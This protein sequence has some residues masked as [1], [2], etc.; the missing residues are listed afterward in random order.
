MKNKKNSYLP[1]DRTGYQPSQSSLTSGSVNGTK[2]KLPN[3]ADDPIGVNNIAYSEFDYTEDP[4]FGE[5]IDPN[6]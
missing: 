2:T 4:L 3:T 5:E 6:H 1:K